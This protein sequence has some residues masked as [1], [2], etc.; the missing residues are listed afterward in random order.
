VLR[1]LFLEVG[2]INFS[3][4]ENQFVLFLPFFVDKKDAVLA[5]FE[6]KRNIIM[7]LQ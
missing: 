7:E 6:V 1:P 2:S 4:A 5:T 3:I